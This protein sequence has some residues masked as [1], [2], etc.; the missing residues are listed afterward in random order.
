MQEVL[1]RAVP[2]L[3][4]EGAVERPGWL[5]GKPQGEWQETRSQKVGVGAGHTGLLYG[6]VFL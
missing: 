1:R 2:S 4:Q 5:E 3:S 6:F